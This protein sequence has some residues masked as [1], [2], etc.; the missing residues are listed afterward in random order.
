MECGNRPS[1]G[2]RAK[3]AACRGLRVRPS[4][5]PDN[6]ERSMMR[7]WRHGLETFLMFCMWLVLC[8][9][10]TGEDHCSRCRQWEFAEGSQVFQLRNWKETNRNARRST[11]CYQF[12][13]SLVHPLFLLGR[14]LS[15]PLYGGIRIESIDWGGVRP[16]FPSKG[17]SYSSE[18]GLA[19]E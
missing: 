8:F 2:V 19:K 6:K 17:N 9:W 5:S 15:V 18:T 10:V 14:S 3:N 7:A 4:K 13:L 12:L 1:V 11:T 16:S